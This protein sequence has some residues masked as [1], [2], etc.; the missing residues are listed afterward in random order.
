MGR[1]RPA[2]FNYSDIC[3]FHD[4]SPQRAIIGFHG[5]LGLEFFVTPNFSLC[6]D[7]RYIYSKTEC[8]WT[9]SDI[10]NPGITVSGE[11]SD[12]QIDFIVAT[13]GLKIYF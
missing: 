5:G 8:E 10:N 2:L 7:G 6:L 11:I 12:L 13:L 3:H 4:S 9:F 1:H